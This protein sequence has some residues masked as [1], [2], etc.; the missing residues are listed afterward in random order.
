MAKRVSAIPVGYYS[1]TPFLRVI[2]AAAAVEFYKKV[3]KALELNDPRK[4]TT[5]WLSATS[6]LVIRP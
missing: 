5:E 2:A 6:R 4:A 3:F 1:L